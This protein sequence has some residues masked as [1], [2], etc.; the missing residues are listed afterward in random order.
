MIQPAKTPGTSAAIVLLRFKARTGDKEPEVVVE[1]LN[2]LMSA[3]A[4]ESLAFVG[5]FLRSTT[6]EIAEGAAL[7]LAE[8][9]R[10]DAFELLKE[11]WPRAE[12]KMLAFGW[13][14]GATLL[15]AV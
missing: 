4:E 8:S 7:A 15:D 2:A 6:E 1:C 5:Q 3:A 12:T 9:R 13:K 14:Y 10:P 11:R